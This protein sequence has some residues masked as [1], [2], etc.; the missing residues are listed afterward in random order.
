MFVA[1][2]LRGKRRGA[3]MRARRPHEDGVIYQHR[4]NDCALVRAGRFGL[5]RTVVTA[6][7]LPS[8]LFVSCLR[9][10]DRQFGGIEATAR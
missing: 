1:A 2:A 4:V 8:V 3:Q 6:C 10:R 9:P 5:T 7:L